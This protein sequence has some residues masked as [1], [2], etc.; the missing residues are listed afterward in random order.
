MRNFGK[1]C[2]MDIVRQIKMRDEVIGNGRAQLCGHV[3]YVKRL[4][5][6]ERTVLGCMSLSE[7]NVS[8]EAK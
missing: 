4:L 1:K 3:H 5:F 6:G 2:K 7:E 8:V